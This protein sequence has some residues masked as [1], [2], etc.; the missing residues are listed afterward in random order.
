[1]YFSTIFSLLLAQVHVFAKV[2]DC[3]LTSVPQREEVKSLLIFCMSMAL[4]QKD[5]RFL[6]KTI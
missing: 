3:S 5:A 2:S 1:M 4:T 6:F